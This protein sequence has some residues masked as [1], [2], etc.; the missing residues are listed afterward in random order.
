MVLVLLVVF[1][2]TTGSTFFFTTTGLKLS[3]MSMA[4]IVIL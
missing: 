3:R 2:S 4:A 1:V